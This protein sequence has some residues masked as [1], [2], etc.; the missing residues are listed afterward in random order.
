MEVGIKAR[1]GIRGDR[2]TM[3]TEVEGVAPEI[4]F[5]IGWG[6]LIVGEVKLFDQ[7]LDKILS[8]ETMTIPFW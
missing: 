5:E 8:K 1:V 6:M 3:E 4:F 2:P 7:T